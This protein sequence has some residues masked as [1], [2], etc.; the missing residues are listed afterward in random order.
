MSVTYYVALP[1]VPTEDGIAAATATSTAKTQQ[2]NKRQHGRQRNEQI[3]YGVEIKDWDWSFL[4]GVNPMMDR[5]GPYSDYRH[6]HI[7]EPCFDPK[8]SRLNRSI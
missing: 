1:L 6:L 5:E 2:R 3:L 8:I 4:F 7:R